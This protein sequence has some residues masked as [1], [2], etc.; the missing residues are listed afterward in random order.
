MPFSFLLGGEKMDYFGIKE[1]YDITLF[2]T[3]DIEVNGEFLKENEPII[4]FDKIQI[5]HLNEYKNHR[6]AQGGLGNKIFIKWDNSKFVDIS[7][8]EGVISHTGLLLLSNSKIFKNKE[9]Q[10]KIPY[11]EIV[12]SVFEEDKEVLYLKH[13]TTD[14]TFIKKN[15]NK[16]E[17]YDIDNSSSKTKIILKEKGQEISQYLIYYNFNYGDSYSSLILGQRCF[18]GFLRLCGRAKIKNDKDG[19]ET[20]VLV[21]FPKIELMSDLSISW[22]KNARPNIYNLEM[23]AYPIGEQGNQYIGNIT[24]LERDIDADI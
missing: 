8:T 9:E 19:K 20:S 14:I 4:S 1:L 11:N 10:I 7:L 16:I 21:E 3:S 12:E 17:D 22:G 24:L 23:R 5:S 13:S 2:T 18:K 15:D 6:Y